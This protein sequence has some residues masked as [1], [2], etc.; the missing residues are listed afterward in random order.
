MEIPAHILSANP[1]MPYSAVGLT[2]KTSKSVLTKSSTSVLLKLYKRYSVSEI[3]RKVGPT[4][5]V[6]ENRRLKK[7]IWRR[8]KKA[9][10]EARPS[11]EAI[12]AS[13]VGRP[14]LKL[15]VR[16][17]PRA[18]AADKWKI[19]ELKAAGKSNQ[20]I[21]K[22]LDRAQPS[23][24]YALRKMG[25]PDGAGVTAYYSFGELFD[26]QAL[27]YLK[28][29]SGLN[30][31][32]LAKTLGMSF[33]TLDA[34]LSQRYPSRQI[35]F[36]T[37]RRVSEWRA[38]LF[39]QLMSNAAERSR[40]QTDQYSQAQVLL[41]FFPHLRERYLLLQQILDQLAKKLRENP[42]WSQYELEQYLC[43]RAMEEH[44]RKN[45]RDRFKD[46]LPWAPQL[47]PVL[48]RK[49]AALCGVN[50]QQIGFDSMAAAL[51]TTA[52]TISRLVNPAQRKA[53]K[54]ILPDQ[55]RRLISSLSRNARAAD[56]TA[57]KG[58]TAKT[59][60]RKKGKILGD[61]ASRIAIAA[62]CRL[63]GMK[64]YQITSEMYPG[65]SK[66]EAWNAGKSILETHDQKI[67]AEMY[68]LRDMSEAKQWAEFVSHKR[69]VAEAHR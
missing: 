48:G 49:L 5:S 22:E 57:G 65:R 21:A 18:M 29:I 61:T 64:D 8:L 26:R 1:P 27:R 50:H 15:S 19:V 39:R 44:F 67:A 28:Q 51:G 68:R 54:P 31:T 33:A 66:P 69:K 58:S 6:L 56:N 9:G 38:D 34:A 2:D 42:E 23:V 37:A 43:E 25:F 11:G 63:K 3:A 60:G 16:D 17:H 14:R 20:Q 13:K 7:A 35:D 10:Y 12:R 40:E 4:L 24:Y 52:P 32:Q 36:N 53:I 59:R 41:M 45:Q 55:M 47:M 30:V 62:R 46:F